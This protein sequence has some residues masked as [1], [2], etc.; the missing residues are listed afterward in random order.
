VQKNILNI[1][2]VVL[3]VAGIS[4]VGVLYYLNHGGYDNMMQNAQ[5]KDS[6]QEKEDTKAPM[7]SDDSVVTDNQQSMTTTTETSTQVTA[8]KQENYEEDL[9]NI[10][11]EL[12]NMDPDYFSD[13]YSDIKY[14]ICHLF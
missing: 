4:L 13:D 12:N 2:I 7:E 3:I 10:D 6:I 1:F 8:K 9:D 5:M 11:K 14:F